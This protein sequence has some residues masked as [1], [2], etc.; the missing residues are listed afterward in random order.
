MST[1]PSSEN[2]GVIRSKDLASERKC[3]GIAQQNKNK[4]SVLTVS[5]GNVKISSK[6]R[7]RKS[8]ENCAPM[9]HKRTDGIFEDSLPLRKKQKMQLTVAV[10][11]DEMSKD[12][13]VPKNQETQ[14]SGSCESERI[15]NMLTSESPPAEYWEELAEKRREALEETLIENEKLAEENKC[16]KEEVAQLKEENKLLDEMVKEAKEL[17]ELVEGIT[18]ENGEESASDERSCAE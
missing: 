6:G 10:Q 2:M 18:S 9:K 3:F 1:R 16:L 11:T 8:D 12:S 7:K 15:M 4:Q 14:S 13:S 5:D 17:A